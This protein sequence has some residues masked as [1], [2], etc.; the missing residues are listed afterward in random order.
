[1]RGRLFV[2]GVDDNTP[3]SD[4]LDVLTVIVMDTPGEALGKWRSGLDRAGFTAE[5]AASR[6]SAGASTAS[7]Y[8]RSTWGLTPEQV[9]ATRRFHATLEGRT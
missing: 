8:D 7:R 4:V 9:E 1:M 5:A 6:T 3:L 2:S